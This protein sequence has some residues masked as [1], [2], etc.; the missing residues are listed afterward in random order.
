M[1]EPGVVEPLSESARLAWDAAPR[2]CDRGDPAG[3]CL[4]YH[5]VWQYLR[6]LGLI[7]SIRTNTDFLVRTFRDCA[8]SGGYRRVLVSA[9][10]DYSMLAHLNHAFTQERGPLHATVID[11]CETSLFINRWY[12]DRYGVAL[13]T[14]RTDVL[15]Y[16]TE[17]PFDLVCTHNF[18]ARFDPESRRRLVSHWHSLLR[19]GGI[20]ITTQR[21]R[22]NSQA[23]LAFYREDEAREL[24]QRVAAAA[25]THPLVSV[26]PEELGRAVYEY[27]RR[28]GGYVIRTGR[29]LTDLFVE[30]DFDLRLA[31]EGEGLAERARDRPS[32]TAG[33]DTY[34][35]RVV[36]RK[37]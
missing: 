22:P 16:A 12:A 28:K 6:L 27:A 20:V 21:I 18:L 4:W 3:T 1:S 19:P 25:R 29:E 35:L 31:D 13:S 8:R 24:A 15:D 26:D 34:R 7:T 17:E 30:Q 37:R 5:R 2:L 9:T 32:S 23:Q 11:R 33:K 10:A 36:A 14:S